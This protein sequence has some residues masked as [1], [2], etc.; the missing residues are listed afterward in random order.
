V[1]VTGNVAVMAVGMA[2]WAWWAWSRGWLA[3]HG[4]RG[5]EDGWPGVVDTLSIEKQT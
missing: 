5:R 4:G 3:G 2:G 1:A